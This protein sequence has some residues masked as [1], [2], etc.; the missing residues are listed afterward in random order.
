MLK[1]K[2]ILL[3]QISP[4]RSALK[5]S[6]FLSR[7]PSRNQE[8]RQC[9]TIR[10]KVMVWALFCFAFFSREEA[11][12]RQ[13][14]TY[15]VSSFVRVLLNNS[16]KKTK[17][18]TTNIL[19]G[20]LSCRRLTYAVITTTYL[21]RYTQSFPRSAPHQMMPS[22]AT[23]TWRNNCCYRAGRWFFVEMIRRFPNRETKDKDGLML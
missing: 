17:T 3:S 23:S 15:L 22:K 12:A 13:A 18:T 14:G 19:K 10:L 2:S 7:I 8:N 1:R 4:T 9:N 20:P 6:L 5:V 11:N 21:W 16:W